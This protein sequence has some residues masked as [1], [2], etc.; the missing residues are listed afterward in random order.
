ML[1]YFNKSFFSIKDI[2]QLCFLSISQFHGF[3]S[4]FKGKD[5][6]FDAENWLLECWKDFVNFIF[7]FGCLAKRI[8][9]R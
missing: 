1:I 4:Q 6:V 3:T 5:F 2:K 9:I 8:F 7:Q